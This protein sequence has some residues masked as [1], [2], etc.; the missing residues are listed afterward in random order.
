MR[1][2]EFIAD[3]MKRAFQGEA[4][5]GP[6]VLEVLEGV[7]AA[8]AAAHPIAGAHSIWEIVNH[9]SVW[10]PGV[11]RRM[12]G[13]ALELI[14]EQDWPP[15]R[16]RSES[17]WQQTVHQL[18]DGFHALHEAVRSSDDSR[19]QNRVAN[20]DHNVWFMLNGIVQHDLYHAGQIAILKKAVVR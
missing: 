11:L 7:V 19:L 8:Q 6:S 10:H 20:R 13:E 14:G 12:Q 18:K 5:H 2:V 17:A 9:I 4:W 3:Q 1:E 16:D 15:V